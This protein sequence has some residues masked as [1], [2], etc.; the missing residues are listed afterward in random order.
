MCVQM[1]SDRDAT[2]FIVTVVADEDIGVGCGDGPQVS[3]IPSQKNLYRDAP[4]QSMQY[5][6]G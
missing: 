4:G 3:A 2:V 6:Q 1:F 5:Q